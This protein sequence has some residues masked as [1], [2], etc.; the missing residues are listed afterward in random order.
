MGNSL[1]NMAASIK[2]IKYRAL[3]RVVNFDG[4]ERLHKQRSLT[5]LMPHG[6]ALINL[7]DQDTQWIHANG[8]RS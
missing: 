8:I 5:K 1:L 2:V 6:P 4:V 3:E 7:P